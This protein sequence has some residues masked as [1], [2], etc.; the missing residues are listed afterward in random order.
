MLKPNISTSAMAVNAAPNAAPS[1]LATY[2]K[3]KLEV[4]PRSCFTKAIIAG[5]VA[6]MKMHH[7]RMEIAIATAEPSRYATLPAS[8]NLSSTLSPSENRNG[9]TNAPAP[10]INSMTP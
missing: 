8:P 1:T 3:L 2:K 5:N 7:G 10:I 9:T 6:P 4:S